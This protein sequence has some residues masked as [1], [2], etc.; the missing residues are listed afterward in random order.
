MRNG[1]TKINT[2]RQQMWIR[3]TNASKIGWGFQDRD[4][5]RWR[6]VLDQSWR[7]LHLDG[8]QMKEIKFKA[9]AQKDFTSINPKLHQGISISKCTKEGNI[10]RFQ[11][12]DYFPNIKEK[13]FMEL[14]NIRMECIVSQG[15]PNI[16]KKRNVQVKLIKCIRQA[17]VASY[18]PFVQSKG[19]KSI[20]IQ[21]ANRWHMVLHQILFTLPTL[22]SYWPM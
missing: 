9:W 1:S 12:R 21:G 20:F 6:W 13:L 15:I 3:K 17:E 16:M 18:S 8:E 4:S 19:A 7:R 11:D 2:S 14:F 22:I 5:R 10:S